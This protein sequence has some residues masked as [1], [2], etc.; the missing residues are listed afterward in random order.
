M[1]ITDWWEFPYMQELIIQGNSSLPYIF[2]GAHFYCDNTIVTPH[3]L[4]EF[5]EELLWTLLPN[6]N[7]SD[8]CEGDE[9][10]DDSIEI[11]TNDDGSEI[12]TDD[13]NSEIDSDHSNISYDMSMEEQD[14]SSAGL[15]HWII[16]SLQHCK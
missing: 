11:D 15:L 10:N 8:S 5:D 7:S 3:Y 1:A 13:S 4:L 6:E 2:C 14:S 12:D 9:M 16:A